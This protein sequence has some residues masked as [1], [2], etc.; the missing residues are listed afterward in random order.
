MSPIAR[1]DATP[2]GSLTTAGLGL[3]AQRRLALGAAAA[4]TAGTAVVAAA[5]PS[6]PGRYGLCPTLALTGWWCPL[7]GSLRAVHALV[8]GDIA[9]AA[10]FNLL[11]IVALPLAIY[12]WA[13]WA[14]PVF[15]LRGPPRWRPSPRVGLGLLAAGVLVLAVFG[16]ARNLAAFA[17]LA[18]A[19][20]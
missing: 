13:A 14:A 15:G 11:L 9:G 6:V 10:D 2:A 8:H 4:A 17:W 18:P 16:V 3:R 19:A 12:A 20:G 7:C 5:D 1:C